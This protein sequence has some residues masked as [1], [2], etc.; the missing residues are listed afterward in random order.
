VSWPV[1]HDQVLIGHVA[2]QNPDHAQGEVEPGRHL[3]D[4]QD[5]MAQGGDGALLDGQLGRWP[6]TER[7]ET[8]R[9]DLQVVMGGP[10]PLVIA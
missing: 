4:G 2:D 5:V 9:L 7:V 3:S 10:G 6:P 8:Q 1:D